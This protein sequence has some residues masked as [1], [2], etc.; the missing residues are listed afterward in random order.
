M[1]SCSMSSVR[2]V[3]RRRNFLVYVGT[4]FALHRVGCVFFLLQGSGPSRCLILGTSST[5][6]TGSTSI[7]ISID[8]FSVSFPLWRHLSN[9]SLNLVR[10]AMQA[11]SCNLFLL[12][13]ARKS[14]FCNFQLVFLQLKV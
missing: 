3:C 11:K 1:V 14:I 9:L 5:P 10:L 12:F 7:I 13:L 4:R 6:K 2:V 8:V